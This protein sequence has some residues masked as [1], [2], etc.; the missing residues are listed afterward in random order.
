MKQLYGV[1]QKP[2]KLCYTIFATYTKSLTLTL[3]GIN[4]NVRRTYE[5][6]MMMPLCRNQLN[7]NEVKTH[8]VQKLAQ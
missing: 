3:E 4:H 7:L 5:I 1:L 2:Q 6:V 8:I